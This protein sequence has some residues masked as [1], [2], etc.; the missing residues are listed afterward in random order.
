MATSET[1]SERKAKIAIVGS[2]LIGKS[3]AMLF[4]SSGHD[5]KL[6]DVS[7]EYLRRALCDIEKQLSD[8]FEAEL[9]RGSLT[10]TQIISHITMA[11]CLED[12]ECVPEDKELKRS[13][14]KEIDDIIESR[15]VVLASSTSTIVPSL[16]SDHLKHKERFMVAHPANPPFLN[17]MV[18][19]VPAPWTQES[20]IEW[21]R[22]LAEGIGQVPIVL[23]KEI[24][25][26]VS[27]RIQAAIQNVAWHLIT[28]LGGW[29]AFMG[30]FEAEHLNRPGG[31]A[32]LSKYGSVVERIL[33]TFPVPELMQGPKVAILAH[34]LE[35]W[36][37]RDRL[38]DRI[39]WRDR[40]MS[41]LLQL[42][43]RL[44]EEEKQAASNAS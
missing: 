31:F 18:E 17:P 3:F 21:A 16:L 36:T 33:K 1:E 28:G 15:D 23:K 37:Q 4:A 27:S 8:L 6:Y 14:W 40:R 32:H 38:A 43:R 13:V 41:A 22:E 9:Q 30:P 5:V 26:F 42:K 20:A 44:D 2:G 24:D 35:Q 34:A 12:C 10:L 11:T 39:R 19:L 29:Y 25:G 7:T